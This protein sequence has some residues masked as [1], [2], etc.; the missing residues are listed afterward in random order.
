MLPTD[1]TA[2]TNTPSALNVSSLNRANTATARSLTPV[3]HAGTTVSTFI[4]CCCEAMS[5]CTTHTKAPEA[6]VSPPAPGLASSQIP[7]YNIAVAEGVVKMRQKTFIG[8][9]W[10]H[11]FLR[12]DGGR[13]RIYEGKEPTGAVTASVDVS[14]YVIKTSSAFPLLKQTCNWQSR[15]GGLTIK[16]VLRRK[17]GRVQKIWMKMTKGHQEQNSNTGNAYHFVARDMNDMV[18]WARMLEFAQLKKDGWVIS[19]NGEAI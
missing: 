19:V 11:A 2:D 18:Y 4:P 14:D 12:L 13:L 16:L 6:G 17:V 7:S 9:R 8:H 15:A 3:M 10:R 5:P 1:G